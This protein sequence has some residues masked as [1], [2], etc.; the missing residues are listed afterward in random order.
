M[1]TWEWKAGDAW[2]PYDEKSNQ[3]IVKAARKNKTIV[4]ISAPSGTI[5]IIDLIGGRQVQKNA[6][7]KS[8]RVRWNDGSL[9]RT[10]PKVGTST[11]EKQHLI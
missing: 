1:A 10:L 7:S 8:R 6:P 5:Y 3:K 9:P 4:E 11:H 2:V